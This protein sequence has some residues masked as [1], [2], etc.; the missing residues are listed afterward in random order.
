MIC[1]GCGGELKSWERAQP[2]TVWGMRSTVAS[3]CTDCLRDG[4]LAGG[5]KKSLDRLVH[6]GDPD[7][8]EQ[9][10]IREM[11]PIN[12][13]DVLADVAKE[14]GFTFEIPDGAK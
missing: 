11:T 12:F 4:Q 8:E 3:F 2:M 6:G 14:H 9:K 13:G 1:P 7:P 10:R 5:S